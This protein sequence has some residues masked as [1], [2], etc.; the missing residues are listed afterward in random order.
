M[1]AWKLVK[2]SFES[3]GKNK[4]RSFLTILGI[5][6]GVSAVIIMISIGLGAQREIEARIASL[7]TNLI[8]VTP[9]TSSA[10]G[11]R[12]AAGSFSRLTLEDFDLIK[13]DATYLEG[14]SPVI[15][16]RGQ[17]IGGDGNWNTSISGVSLDYLT[18]RFWDVESGYSFTESDIK[19]K[20][21]VCLLGKTVAANL[22]PDSDPVGQKIR[23]RNVP[24][25]VIGVLS[26]KGQSVG[27]S[28][29]DDIIIAPYTTV[30]TRLSGRNFIPQIMCSA[31]NSEFIELAQEEVRELM[32][33]SHELD[34][35]AGD[36]DNFT[37]R[38]QSEITEAQTESTQV[39]T[40]L[41]ASIAGVS[42]LVGG[43]GIMNIML[44]SV[45]ERTREIGIR[46]ALGARESDILTQFLVEAVVLSLFGG[47]L[48]IFLGFGGIYLVEAISGMATAVDSDA[49]LLAF[50]FSGVIGILFG[51]LPARKAAAL[52]PIDALQFQ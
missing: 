2:I 14:V 21:K 3:I 5:I 31:I 48:G 29:S 18:I 36:Q 7:G 37:V 12:Q 45:T 15:T 13:K 52:N 16:T 9:G 20:K 27:G 4:L 1:L 22:F 35:F 24:F 33:I 49:I 26:Q 32:R 25:E 11:V 51:F 42:L 40:T 41:L 6:I 34:P 8:L 50:S 19:G 43:I 46:V 10:S 44:V 17:I 30:K 39:M 28:D 47:L 23:I 38:N